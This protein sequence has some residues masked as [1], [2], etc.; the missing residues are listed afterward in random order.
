MRDRPVFINGSEYKIGVHGK[1]FIWLNEEWKLSQ[2]PAAEVVRAI[3]RL[4][5]FRVEKNDRNM[6]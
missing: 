6:P 2:R 4:D 3:E 1:V 5:E